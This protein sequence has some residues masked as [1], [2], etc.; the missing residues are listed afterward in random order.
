ML[1]LRIEIMRSLG[2]ERMHGNYH[3]RDRLR[4]VVKARQT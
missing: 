1:T 3:Q 4:F 2:A